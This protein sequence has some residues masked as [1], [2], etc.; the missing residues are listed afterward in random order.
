MRIT[1]RHAQDMSVYANEISNGRIGVCNLGADLGSGSRV[2]D[3]NRQLVWLGQPREAA[4]YYIGQIDAY[5]EAL[6]QA[7]N[8]LPDSVRAVRLEILEDDHRDKVVAWY[9]RGVNDGAD[10]AAERDA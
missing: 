3:N 2:I 6:G 5:R 4:A 7:E 10:R 9:Q 8:P 1:G